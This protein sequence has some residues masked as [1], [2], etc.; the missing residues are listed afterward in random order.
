MI[1]ISRLFAIFM[2]QFFTTKNQVNSN[3]LKGI[4][5]F[6]IHAWSR[7]L[8]SFGGCHL[9]GDLIALFLHWIWFH[10]VT[11]TTCI[12]VAFD[13]QLS[14]S[15]SRFL[16]TSIVWHKSCAIDMV[17]TLSYQNDLL[18]E[19]PREIL[20][21]FCLWRYSFSIRVKP[22]HI[23][24]IWIFIWW[25]NSKLP[26]LKFKWIK[27]HSNC[28]RIVDLRKLIVQNHMFN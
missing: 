28:K 11:A 2:V 4:F 21:S 19:K 24:S 5:S 12:W 15:I 13:P 26:E 14:L 7:L 18:T 20:R 16:F 17:W 27:H 10:K 6:I 9:P 8:L 23:F 22:T 3:D 25:G 1:E